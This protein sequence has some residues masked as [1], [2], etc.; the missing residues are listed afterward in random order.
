MERGRASRRPPSPGSATTWHHWYLMNVLSIG[1]FFAKLLQPSVIY[2]LNH[3]T[4][5]FASKNINKWTFTICTKNIQM[6]EILVQ[7]TID[8][9][10]HMQIHG[11]FYLLHSLHVRMYYCRG[12]VGT[13]HK[14]IFTSRVRSTRERNVF[15]LFVR[16]EGGGGPCSLVSRSFTAWRGWGVPVLVLAGGRGSSLWS[17]VPLGEGQRVP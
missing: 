14:A 6:Y 8:K 16:P 17:Q 3:L 11:I 4:H 5:N 12:N 13:Y 10:I 2:P 15:N 9:R 1:P 7:C